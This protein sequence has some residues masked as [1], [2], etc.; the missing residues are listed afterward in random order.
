MG[1][2]LWLPRYKVANPMQRVRSLKHSKG[3]VF[4]PKHFNILVLHH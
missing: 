4:D 3:D 2:L 1:I